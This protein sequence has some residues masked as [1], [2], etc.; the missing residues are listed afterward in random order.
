M[1]LSTGTHMAP[2]DAPWHQLKPWGAHLPPECSRHTTQLTLQKGLLEQRVHGVEDRLRGWAPQEGEQELGI[3]IHL[4]YPSVLQTVSQ[5][6][7][8]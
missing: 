4:Q 6:Q 2:K 5:V 7:H 1:V 3:L 8:Q